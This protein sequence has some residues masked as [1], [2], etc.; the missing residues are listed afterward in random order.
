MTSAVN[1]M[2]KTKHRRFA[3]NNV[4]VV[5]KS[6]NDLP[7]KISTRSTITSKYSN[8]VIPVFLI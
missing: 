8:T 1:V 5:L 3:Y 7:F 6:Y 4:L 2:R